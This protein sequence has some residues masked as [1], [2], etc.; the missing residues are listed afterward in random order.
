MLKKFKHL[1]TAKSMFNSSIEMSN[2]L[3][4]LAKFIVIIVHSNGLLLRFNLYNITAKFKLLSLLHL[5]VLLVTN[6]R[7]YA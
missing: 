5:N 6:S 4:N 7:S 2:E 1:S 3:F